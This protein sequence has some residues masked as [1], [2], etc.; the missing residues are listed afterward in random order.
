MALSSLISVGCLDAPNQGNTGAD[1]STVCKN[2]D[3][4][5]L[6]TLDDVNAATGG[7]FNDIEPGF[8]GDMGPDLFSDS[9]WYNAGGERLVA[10]RTCYVDPGAASANFDAE[11]L[12]GART[13]VPGVGDRA[14]FGVDA[15]EGGFAPVPRLYVL[16][17][18]L[19]V[20]IDDTGAP[21]RGNTEAS[22]VQ[23][24]N[25]LLEQP[26]GARAP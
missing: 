7:S 9:C 3:I 18:R 26:N 13:P 21:A 23:L 14:L 15:I 20:D 6:L 5:A 1:A 12:G 19:I 2:V 4:C 25:T 22:F 8:K 16:S 11:V 17:G 10:T 24:A